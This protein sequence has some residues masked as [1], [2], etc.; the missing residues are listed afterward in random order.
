MLT[1]EKGLSISYDELARAAQVAIGTLHNHFPHRADLFEA[2]F[3]AQVEEVVRLA[4]RA[5]GVRD[6]WE[7]LVGFMTDTLAL[8]VEH[9]GLHQ[10]LSGVGASV[11][12]AAKAWERIS[13]IAGELLERA[14]SAGV[15]RSDVNHSDVALVPLMV[16]AVIERSRSIDPDL[17]R[18]ALAVV[19]DGLRTGAA[20]PLPD[21]PP[22]ATKFQAILSGQDADA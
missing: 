13:P 5:R 21:R 3:R 17:W 4:E 20:A 2:L 6:P 12:L 16:G 19:M 9:R 15:V 8:Q 22:G 14:Q 10:L 1:A 11:P 18:R 7:A